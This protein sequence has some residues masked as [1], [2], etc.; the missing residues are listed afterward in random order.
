MS[1]LIKPAVFAL[2][3]YAAIV[4]AAQVGLLDVEERALQTPDG[5]RVIA[6]YGKAKP[7]EPTLLYFH[8]NCGSLAVR[9]ERTRR[10]M[11]EGW[12]VYM[13]TYRSYGGSTGSPSETAHVADARL[14]YGALVLEGV[15]PTSI[16][17]YGE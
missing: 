6:W 1:L 12:G 13:M 5:A 4:L 16:I 10:F 15:E 11:G 7:G 17:L 8:G 2:C 3:A 14:A 9:A